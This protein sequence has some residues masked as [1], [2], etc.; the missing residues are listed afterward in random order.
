MKKFRFTKNKFDLEQTTSIG[1]DNEFLCVQL[2]DGSIIKLRIM[3]TAG[4]ERF[5]SINE[6]F[7]KE[8]DCCLLVYD[9]TKKK[10]FKRIKNY[11]IKKIKENCK[12]IFKVVLLGNKTDKNDEREVSEK[13][14][15]DLALKNNYI[16]IESSCKDNYNVSDAFTA[17]VEMTNNDMIKEKENNTN[18]FSLDETKGETFDNKSNSQ[19]SC[20]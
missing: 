9:I 4:Q 7:Y 14:G 17:L 13:D 1:I 19:K 5:D 6:K 20:C 12:N 11:Y 3:D 16:F 10:S 18:N 15:R 8:A 2:T